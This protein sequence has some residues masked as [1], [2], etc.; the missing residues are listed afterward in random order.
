MGYNVDRS[1]GSIDS[2]STEGC[3]FDSHSWTTFECMNEHVSWS[4]IHRYTQ[5]L[6][7]SVG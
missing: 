4:H 7:L 3:G 1:S 5:Y 2:D 6:C